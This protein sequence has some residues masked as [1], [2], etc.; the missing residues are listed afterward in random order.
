MRLR[1]YRGEKIENSIED[2]E[3]RIE[4]IGKSYGIWANQAFYGY[5]SMEV[6][7][8]TAGGCI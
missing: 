1:K 8:E 4:Y 2:R 3:N 5:F 7:S 6:G